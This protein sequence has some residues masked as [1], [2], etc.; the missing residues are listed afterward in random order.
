MNPEPVRIR[1]ATPDDAAALIALVQTLAEEPGRNI[2]LSPGEFQY[3]EEEERQILADYAA[4]DNSLFLVAEAAGQLIG[5][6]NL[7]GGK[8]QSTR[9]AATLGI[10]LIRP[11]RN[12]GVGKLLMAEAVRWAQASG[13]LKRIELKV[14]T[15]NQHAIHLYESFGFQIEGRMR[16]SIFLE[17][18]YLDDLVMGL[19]L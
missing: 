15:R 6:L 7:S 5:N 17:G 16:S 2:T 13:V 10:A 1:K 12:R 9:H 19:L 3:T 4:A 14:F 11:W 8:R 18:E